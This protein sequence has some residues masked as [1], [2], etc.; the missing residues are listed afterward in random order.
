MLISNNHCPGKFNE[1]PKARTPLR[2]SVSFSISGVLRLFLIVLWGRG[3][4]LAKV[5][6]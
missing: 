1:D 2:L 3:M 4:E 5:N 6:R